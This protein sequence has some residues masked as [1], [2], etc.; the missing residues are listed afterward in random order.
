MS[1]VTNWPTV[2]KTDLTA[3]HFLAVTGK[4]K[5]QAISLFPS[6]ATA[7]PGG[8]INMYSGI[9]NQNQL[10]MRELISATT[11]MLTVTVGGTGEVLYTVLPAGF[12]LA[13]MD[14]TTS[15]F[16]ATVDLTADVGATV[17]PVIN[18]GTGLATIAQGSIPY[19]SAANVISA[20]APMTTNGQ[21]LIGSVAGVPALANLI[22]GANITVTNGP[23]T[24]QIDA[25]ISTLL[26][27]L[28][29]DTWH[30]N[31]NAA[32]GISYLS[33]DGTAEGVM[34]DANG[35]VGIG[36]SVPTAIA[37]TSQLSLYGNATN[38]LQIGNN[39]NYKNHSIKALDATGANAGLDLTI[40]GADATVGN[41]NGGDLIL[42]AGSANL[43]GTGASGNAN[44]YPG[45]GSGTATAGTVNLYYYAAGIAAIGLQVDSA[46]NVHLPKGALI[47]DQSS[48]ALV[49]P[50]AVNIVTSKTW[51]TD[52]A[53][54]AL[55]LIDGQEGQ[56]K[57][58]MQIGTSGGSGILTPTN[59]AG[60]LITITFNAVGDSVHLMFTNGFWF[61]IGQNGVVIA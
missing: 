47:D 22:A 5:L 28:D 46:G 49:G 21:L 44:I 17:L 31:L 7:G 48:Q 11:G 54:N 8:G 25:N 2:I 24:I 58:I 57:Y 50:G 27:N 23:G 1:D 4:R 59:L 40:E 10:N 55:T 36:D 61:V 39:N 56:H 26:A 15:L 9:T 19:A 41:N 16:L 60:G 20:S 51:F 14:N 29:A 34:V 43:A 38:A 35:R 45:P 3:S 30:I 52:T 13:L 12:D 32:A 53:A 42:K 33:G 37:L 18:G 6:L